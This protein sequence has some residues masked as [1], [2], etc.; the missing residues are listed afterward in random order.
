MRK[1]Q[2]PAADREP[3]TPAVGEIYRGPSGMK[4]RC[5]AIVEDELPTA[6]LISL[7]SG[8]TFTARSISQNPDGSI[9][10]W[11]SY[12]GKFADEEDTP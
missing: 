12:D 4:I 8:W 5:L 6:R 2:R 11:Y 1:G 3:F 10:W 7:G 9:E